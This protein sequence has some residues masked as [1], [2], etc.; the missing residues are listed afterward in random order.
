MTGQEVQF[1]LTFLTPFDL[2]ADHYFFVPQV[3]L[4]SG[5]FFWLSA[6][7]P[8]PPFSPL[9]LQAWIRNQALEPDWLRA[10]SDIVGPNVA[11]W[12]EVQRG[13]LAAG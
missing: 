12:A 2:P 5:D 9:D 11:D 3:Q 10:G 6:A 7:G 1:N 4:T 13:V 8:V